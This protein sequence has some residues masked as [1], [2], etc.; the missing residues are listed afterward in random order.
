MPAGK[1]AEWVEDQRWGLIVTMD[2]ATNEYYAMQFVVRVR[3]CRGSRRWF[4]STAC[5]ALF[6]PIGAA[7]IGSRHEAGGKVDRRSL[8][9]PSRGEPT[10]DSV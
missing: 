6:I 3:A 2:D 1:T 10:R 4:V 9:V 7:I 5:S 8:R